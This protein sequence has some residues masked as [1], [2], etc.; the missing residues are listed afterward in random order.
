MKRFFCILLAVIIMISTCCVAYAADEDVTN[1][2]YIYFQVP[3]ATSVAWKNF[4]MVFCHIWREGN[5]GGDFYPWQAKDE[6]CTDLQNGYWSYD[7]SGLEFD[8]DATYAVIFSNENGMQTYNLTLT[9][10]CKGD[11][12][13]CNGDTCVNPV[14]SAKQCTVARWYANADTVFPCAQVS[15]DGAIVDP[16]GVFNADINRKWGSSE[17]VSITMP[18]VELT[19]VETE[20]E[21]VVE[22]GNSGV[23]SSLST[24]LFVAIG[25]GVVAV[26]VVVI[27]IVLKNRKKQ[28]NS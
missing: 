14:D 28:V 20:A 26:A 15:S 13:V 5:E 6:R 12:V 19:V 11:I 24:I 10:D 23:A 7:I 2:D 17:G 4:S 22:S 8:E 3:T 27:L 1:P 9:S 21:T 16:D 25:V 18:E